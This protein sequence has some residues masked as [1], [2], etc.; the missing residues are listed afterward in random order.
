MRKSIYSKNKIFK[1]S[2]DK[3]SSLISKGV[4]VENLLSILEGEYL[5][6][7][8]KSFIKD[9]GSVKYF[10]KVDRIQIVYRILSIIV[11]SQFVVNFLLVVFFANLAKMSRSVAE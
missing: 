4:K 11:L 9:L 7:E 10:N 6:N 3:I 8:I 5:P 2:Y 1:K